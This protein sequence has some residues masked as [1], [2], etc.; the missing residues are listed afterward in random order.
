M[1]GDTFYEGAI[2]T[3][4]QICEEIKSGRIVID[5]FNMENLNDNS[6]NVTLSKN[7]TTY[8]LRMSDDLVVD[9]KHPPKTITATMSEK[10][11]FVI[12]PGALYLGS[13]NERIA[14]D[15]FVPILAGRSSFGRL[16]LTSH[17]TGNFGDLGYNGVWTMQI[18]STF[19]TRIY[20]DIKIG[21]IY[22]LRPYGKIKSL[23][24]GK[25][26]GSTGPASS[27]LDLDFKR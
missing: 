3:G 21:Q 18:T 27:R 16:G 17:K 2:L 7:I 20:P 6:Y 24:H 10:Y 11:G 25:Y 9:I 4:D 12:Y 8:D 19:P 23:Y 13:T 15:Y 26:Q 22:F 5:P 14:S 1:M